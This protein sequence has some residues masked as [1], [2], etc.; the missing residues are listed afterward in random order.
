MQIKTT[1]QLKQSTPTRMT[2]MKKAEYSK[3]W[4]A[5]RATN[6]QIGTIWN[7]FWQAM[8]SWTYAFPMTQK[9][10][11]SVNTQKKW[12]HMFPKRHVLEYS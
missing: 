10:H 11:S 12:V 2:T 6:V 4:P 8:L 9:F 5:R 1:M 7:A 3:H